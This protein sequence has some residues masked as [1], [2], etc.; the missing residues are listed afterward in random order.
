MCVDACA[1]RRRSYSTRHPW[2]MYVICLYVCACLA[3]PLPL[4]PIKFCGLVIARDNWS[5][6]SLICISPTFQLVVYTLTNFT[7][8]LTPN[9]VPHTTAVA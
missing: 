9:E 1:Q 8:L 2:A 5:G 7:L 3:S 4:A 6:N